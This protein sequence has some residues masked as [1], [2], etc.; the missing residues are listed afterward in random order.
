[1]CV[2]VRYGVYGT[3]GVC[4]WFGAC[5]GHV[6][7]VCV[8]GMYVCVIQWIVWGVVMNVG[9]GVVYRGM[10]YGAEGQV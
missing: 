8:W 2:C 9:A 5:V 3:C 7:G 6:S 10:V 1:M 4:I